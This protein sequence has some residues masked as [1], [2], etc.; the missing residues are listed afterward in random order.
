MLVIIIWSIITF[1]EVKKQLFI[2]IHVKKHFQNIFNNTFLGCNL[3]TL[4]LQ[5]IWNLILKSNVF[6]MNQE[7][8]REMVVLITPIPRLFPTY[9]SCLNVFQIGTF[10][11]ECN[12]SFQFQRYNFCKV[13]H[14]LVRMIAVSKVHLLELRG[15][16]GFFLYGNFNCFVV[17]AQALL[18]ILRL[19]PGATKRNL[20]INLSCPWLKEKRNSI[21]GVKYLPSLLQRVV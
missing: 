21:T 20:I 11:K 5:Y 9:P 8:L 2:D 19:F 7:R 14:N 6:T 10:T 4:L 17:V 1:S 15:W 18:R 16:I 12:F 13:C 3:F